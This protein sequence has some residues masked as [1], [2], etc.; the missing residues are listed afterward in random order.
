MRKN[1]FLTL[2]LAFASLAGINAQEW[3][4]TLDARDGLPG[5][6]ETKGGNTVRCYKSDVIRPTEALKTLR[7]SVAGNKNGEKPH[8]GNFVTALSELVVYA[9]D[10]ETKIPYTVTSNADH[11]SVGDGNDGDGLKA[12]NDGK[13]NNFWHS[14]YSSKLVVT[15][16]HHLELTFTEPISEFILEWGAR[17]GE[18]KNA[19][20]V[21]G[22]T[23]GGVDFVP[24]S[25]WAFKKGEQ[26]TSME[27]LE[28]AQYFVMKSNIPVEYDTYVNNHE[29][30]QP[31]G[32]KTNKEVQTGPGS[33][34]VATDATAEEVDASLAYQLIPAEE[35]GYYIYS[36][37]SEKFLMGTWGGENGGIT[38]TANISEA[39]IF[40][41]TE[42]NGK[43][44][45]YFM[46]EHEGE[47]LE[48]HLGARVNNSFFKTVDKPRYEEFKTGKPY[49]LNF[50]YIIGFDWTLEAVSMNYPIRYTLKPLK[51]TIKEAKN[52]HAIMGNAAVEGSEENYDEFLS[53][54]EE[55]D[56]KCANDAYTRVDEIN[57]DIERLKAAISWYL[58]SKVNWYCDVYEGEF[59][60]LEDSCYSSSDPHEGYYTYEAHET[61][62]AIIFDNVWD[63]R[64]NAGNDAPAYYEEL[65]EYIIT[66]KN[67][68]DAFFASK[69][70]FISLPKVYTCADPHH[71]P[72]GV[73]VNDGHLDGRYD[74]EQY[75]SLS[76]A[77]DGIR[78]TFLETNVGGAASDGKFKNY[79]MVALSGLEI[80]DSDGNKL[81]LTAELVTSNSEETHERENG[82]GTIDKLFDDDVLTY[83]HSAWGDAARYD[84]PYTYIHFDIKF[85]EGQAL[86]TFTVKTIGRTNQKVASLA[87]GTV[88]ITSYGEEYDPIIFRENPYKV[89]LVKQITDVKDIKDGGIYIISGNIYAKTKNAAPFYYSGTQHYHTNI[90]AA[91][92]DPCVYMFKQ[93]G[94]AWNIISLSNAQY[95]A[96]NKAENKVKDEETGKTKTVAEWSTGLTV[97]PSKAAPIKIEA[98]GNIEN[99]FVLYSDIEDN[100][101]N[102]SFSWTNPKNESDV[103]EIAETSV[104]ANKFVFMDW[105]YLTGRACATVLPGDISVGADK[106]KN[107]SLAD[108]FVN[109]DNT[110]GGTEDENGWNAAAAAGDNLHFNKANGEGE[111]NIYEVKMN[112]EYYLWAN[113]IPA[114]LEPLALVTGKDPGCISSDITAL[115]AAIED[116]KAVVENENKEGAKT[117]VEAF[118]ANVDLAENAE[119]V[120]VMDGY[121]YAIE[122]AYPEYYNKQEVVKAIY[123]DGDKLLWGDAPAAYDKANAKYVFQFVKYDGEDV[124]IPEGEEDNVFMIRSEKDLYVAKCEKSEPVVMTDDYGA[125]PYLIKPLETN[126]YGFTSLEGTF[127]L[128]TGGHGSG[129][130]SGGDVVGWNEG[131]RTASSWRIRF[132]DDAKGTN[133]EDLVVEGAEVVSVAYYTASGAAIPAPVSGINIV[134]TVYSNGVIET[135]KVLVK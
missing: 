102:A 117:A 57:T 6:V 69:V 96:L 129:A 100:P 123:T 59:L 79:P 39:A 33:V 85:P 9:A 73:K 87:P 84:Q 97:L 118:V 46:M 25:E 8:E 13:W 30:D 91:T 131:A 50:S 61:A 107:H 125:S 29:G 122:S 31:Y 5:Q 135:K 23:K 67:A 22:L 83:Y 27:A 88:C 74:W 18:D 72:L 130:G 55:C 111:W 93:N 127:M 56:N 128:H 98:S 20:T 77:V 116:V 1:L 17:P 120:Q 95:W 34:Y 106:L 82:N 109:G 12:L 21:V 126:I 112:D 48:I 75:V 103:I 108:Y 36:M 63:L 105:G 35:G 132:V 70:E 92:N 51:E 11:N 40:T 86:K 58:Y 124:E 110:L 49:C 119:R 52:I 53:V 60:A 133:I 99:A 32:T 64:D 71:T 121:W 101:V 114:T 16:Y 37:K 43:F 44:E 38:T 28:S 89:E 3:S 78:L 90:K 62:Y 10:G 104:N 65:K 41:I 66:A 54:L 42:N 2:A 68:L 7:F 115:T 76:E 81:A 26:I 94:D 15:E 47:E 45:M 4:M 14:S 113:G 134:V 24:Y 19:P 80:L